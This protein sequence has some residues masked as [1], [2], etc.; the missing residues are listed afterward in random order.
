MS[1]AGGGGGSTP[2]GGTSGGGGPIGG[3]LRAKSEAKRP[4]IVWAS[5]DESPAASY[6]SARTTRRS[7]VIS[8]TV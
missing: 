4:V 2:G 1:A 8:R 7:S 5:L 3:P 6:R